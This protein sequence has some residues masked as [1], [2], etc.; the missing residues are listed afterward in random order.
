MKLLLIGAGNMGAALYERW[1]GEHDLSVLEKNETI[2]AALSDRFGDICFVPEAKAETDSVVVLAVKP[3]SI[4]SVKITGRPRAIVSIMAGVSL[5]SLRKRFSADLFVRAI[6]NLAAIYGKSATT[7][8]GDDEF[9]R[10]A[11]GLFERAGAALWVESE[12]EIAIATALAGSGTGFLA[13]AAEAMGDAAVCLGMKPGDARKLTAA[14][15]DGMGDLLAHEHPA[16][17]RE[18]VCSPGGTTI[19]GIASLETNG[20][21]SGFFEAIRAAFERSNEL[22]ALR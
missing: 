5:Q 21:R 17:L 12:Q 15:F 22:G 4:D 20:V 8:T 11:I 16:L 2:R 6:P 3:Q 10:E 19:A 7:L 18:R 13:L 1:R 14:L 9:K